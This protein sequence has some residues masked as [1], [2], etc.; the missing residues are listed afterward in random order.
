MYM[1]ARVNTPTFTQ[2]AHIRLPGPC[3]LA[4]RFLPLSLFLPLPLP[5]PLEVPQAEAL[6]VGLV[7]VEVLNETPVT[8]G[9]GMSHT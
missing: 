3:C 1:H 4:I 9:T 8:S 5:L 7:V 6:G 2:H